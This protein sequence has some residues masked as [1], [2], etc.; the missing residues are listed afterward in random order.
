M[1]ARLIIE[2]IGWQ[3]PTQNP[4]TDEARGRD[5]FYCPHRNIWRGMPSRPLT[6]LT[7]LKPFALYVLND[8]QT[9]LRAPSVGHCIVV[10]IRF[11]RVR[12]VFTA[13]GLLIW[14]LPR[15]VESEDEFNR[16]GYDLFH[17]IAIGWQGNA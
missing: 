13:S 7:D 4:R 11:F 16:Y 17:L 14:I 2:A 8:F 15:E 12:Q 5:T 10:I 9:H 1:T 6:D 3:V